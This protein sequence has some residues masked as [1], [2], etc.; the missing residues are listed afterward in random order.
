VT[1]ILAVTA[2]FLGAWRGIDG[3]FVALAGLAFGLA[4]EL[5]VVYNLI[6]LLP[7]FRI[8]VNLRT[9]VLLGF[10]LAVLAGRGLDLLQALPGSRVPEVLRR[11]RVGLVLASLGVAGGAIYVAAINSPE[12]LRAKMIP[13]GYDRLADMLVRQSASRV[14]FL[15]AAGVAIHLALRP[16]SGRRWRAWLVP[17]V[18]VADLFAYGRNYNPAIPP[19]LD[20]PPHAALEFVKAQPGLFRIVAL[21]AAFPPN[22]NLVYGLQDARG[23]SVLEIDSYLR[24][25]D[26][27]G[28]YPQPFLHFRTMYFSNFESRLVDLLNVRFVLSDRPL[29]HPK[30]ALRFERGLRVYENLAVLPRAF[31]VYRTRAVDGRAAAERALRDPAFDP[32]GEVILE[33]PAPVTGDPDPAAAVRIAEYG[34]NRVVAEVSTAAPAVLVLSDSWFPGWEATLDG[35]PVPLLRADLA[36]RGVAVP[37]GRHRVVFRYFPGSVRLGLALSGLAVA[38]AVGLLAWPARRRPPAGPRDGSSPVP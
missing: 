2:V 3:F 28:E 24:F 36:F 26:A 20:Y 17:A 32:A 7:L 4:Y 13:D 34:P 27:T 1:L 19:R 37:A 33:G 14:A 38:V 29:Q 9:V 18:L 23:Y 16:G 12:S 30:L 5:P 31:L 11:I 8:S 22:T 35:A 25:L 15:A 10:A 21:D 6:H